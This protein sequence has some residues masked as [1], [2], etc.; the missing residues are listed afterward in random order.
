MLPPYDI[1]VSQ[2]GYYNFKTSQALI[3]T[4]TFRNVTSKLSPVLGIYDIEIYDFEFYCYDP[5]PEIKKSKDEQISATIIH[6]LQ[7]F[8]S[9]DLRVLIYACDSSDR[10]HR[11]RQWL[12]NH[13]YKTFAESIKRYQL[14]IKIEDD[15]FE[16]AAHGAV[17]TTID[18][19]YQNV[20]QS[21]LLDQVHGILLEKYGQ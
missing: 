14:D 7:Q 18:F 11:E 20:L 6:L 10:L 4:C 5:T 15:K 16:I 2:E 1:I 9:S 19:P 17:L 21:E 8:F 3:Y 12:F 13:W